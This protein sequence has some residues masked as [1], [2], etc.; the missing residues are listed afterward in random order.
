MNCSNHC[1]QTFR[2]CPPHC[3]SSRRSQN[4]MCVQGHKGKDVFKK[5]NLSMYETKELVCSGFDK[6]I[7]LKPARSYSDQWGRR[8]D[9]PR[10]CLPILPSTNAQLLRNDTRHHRAQRTQHAKF[11][12]CSDPG[13]PKFLTTRREPWHFVNKNLHMTLSLRNRVRPTR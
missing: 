5:L 3:S 9:L 1:F 8:N 6:V 13:G 7:G 2:F 4:I 12:L 11:R 10:P